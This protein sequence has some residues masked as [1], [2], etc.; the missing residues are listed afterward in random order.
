MKTI[1]R[2]VSEC[3]VDI[4]PP[5]ALHQERLLPSS[6]LYTVHFGPLLTRCAAYMTKPFFFCFSS[7]VDTSFTVVEK[8]KRA[9]PLQFGCCCLV[10]GATN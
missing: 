8:N 3:K 9:D 7:Q 1:T 5:R 10:Y 6:I 4:N 2:H